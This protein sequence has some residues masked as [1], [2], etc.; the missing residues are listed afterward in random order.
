MDEKIYYHGGVP[1]LSVGAFIL[2]PTVTGSRSWADHDI[3]PGA[4]TRLVYVTTSLKAAR[5]YAAIYKSLATMFKS[6]PIDDGWVYKVQPVP[7]VERDALVW[8][9]KNYP[10]PALSMIGAANLRYQCPFAT[11]LEVYPKTE[12]ENTAF[13]NEVTNAVLEPSRQAGR[14]FAN[15]LLWLGGRKSLGDFIDSVN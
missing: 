12:A 3:V 10:Y 13:L 9:D 8:G 5:Y 15:C 11:I 6:P 1:N 4:S 14:N 2:P 7:P